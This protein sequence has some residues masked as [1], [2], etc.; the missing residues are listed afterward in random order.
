MKMKK[1]KRKR[2]QYSLQSAVV[3]VEENVINSTDPLL[4]DGRVVKTNV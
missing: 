1:D 3:V 4:N 2:G